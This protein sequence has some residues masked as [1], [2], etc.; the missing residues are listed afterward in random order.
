MMF[1]A[2]V[3]ACSIETGTKIYN[4]TPEIF[5]V[6][7]VDGDSVIAGASETFVVQVSDLD[8]SIDEMLVSV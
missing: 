4:N 7:H 6:S 5:F 2:L 1:I 3:F 8:N